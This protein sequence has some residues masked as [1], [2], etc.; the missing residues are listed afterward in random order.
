LAETCRRQH[1]K[2]GYK[3]GC[4]LTYL[5]LNKVKFGSPARI[6]DPENLE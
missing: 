5:P 2:L 3:D 1:N 4:V 6:K